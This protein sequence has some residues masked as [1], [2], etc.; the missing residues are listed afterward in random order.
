MRT[1]NPNS[2]LPS[3]MQKCTCGSLHPTFDLCG[4]EA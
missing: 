1:Y 3:L 4:G 2:L